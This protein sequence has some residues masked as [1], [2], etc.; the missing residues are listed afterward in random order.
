[1]R[2]MTTDTTDTPIPAVTATTMPAVPPPG[3]PPVTPAVTA[4]ATTAAAQHPKA[5][6][7][8]EADLVILGCMVEALDPGLL[9]EIRATRDRLAALAAEPATG[10]P[11]AALP[12]V[13]QIT[14]LCDRLVH[15]VAQIDPPSP[16]GTGRGLPDPTTA[17]D[18]ESDRL[19]DAACETYERVARWS[20]AAE[21]WALVER[22][23]AAHPIAPSLPRCSPSAGNAGSREAPCAGQAGPKRVSSRKTAARAIADWV[24]RV[25]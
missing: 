7:A 2:P 9:A 23:A 17:L 1:M 10:P 5:D 16:S 15:V 19:P 20:G 21:L 24:R 18:A 6:E 4:A 8:D 12:V 14:P 22:L 11:V 3:A 25:A 13:R